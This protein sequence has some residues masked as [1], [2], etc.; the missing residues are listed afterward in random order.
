MKKWFFMAFSIF[1][2]F[3]CSNTENQPTR[4][5]T[6]AEKTAFILDVLVLSAIYNETNFGAGKEYIKIDTT[7]NSNS[8]TNTTSSGNVTQTNTVTTSTTKSKSKGF[9]FGIGY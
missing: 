5:K 9:G 7:T 1:V 8:I 4:E 2:L 6:A 3:G